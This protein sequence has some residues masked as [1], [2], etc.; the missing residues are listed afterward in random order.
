M[1]TLIV[2]NYW[3][4]YRHELFTELSKYT[5][6]EILY[7]GKVGADRLW[8]KEETGFPSIQLN[9]KRIGPFLFSSLRGIDFTKYDQAVLLEHMENI[10][11][12]LKLAG[13]FKGRFILWTGM[14]KD[15]HPE[16]FSYDFFSKIIKSWYRRYLYRANCF[17]AYSELS[18][19]MLLKWGVP[20]KK[21]EIIH[22]A[23]RI[24]ELSEIIDQDPVKLRE[25]RSGPLRLLSLGYLRKEKNNNFL[26]KVCGRFS[27]TQ[28]EL[29]I[30][31]DG[32][33]RE[34]L[35]AM[36]GDNVRFKGYLEGEDKFREYLS[37]DVFVLPTIRDPWAL[38]VNEA[39]YYGL[40]VIC[41]SRAGARDMVMGNGFVINPFD[42]EDLYTAIKTL[43]DNR[44]LCEKMGRRSREIVQDYTINFAAKQMGK[45]LESD[46]S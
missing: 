36:G 43:V 28:V 30:V 33:E 31:G 13:L 7:L 22:Q 19:E 3:T 9:A 34:N 25:G 23:S 32:P 1:K 35:C 11:T 8:K 5:D 40:P 42:E 10:F 14:A 16:K 44:G 37:A 26:I 21:I 15:A 27:R 45:L 4:P 6:I 17:F 38:V 2:Q 29:L 20:A 24:L 46:D 18:R 12:V 41:S 39:M